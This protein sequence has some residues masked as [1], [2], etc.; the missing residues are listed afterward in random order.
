MTGAK[1]TI[2]AAEAGRILACAFLDADECWRDV[3]LL[4]E[5][6]AP[7][8]VATCEMAF[9]RAAVIKHT[10]RWYQ[11]AAT[12]DLMSCAVDQVITEAFASEDTELTLAYYGNER[13]AVVAPRTVSFYEENV[14]P[15]THLAAVF[16]SRLRVPGFSTLEIAPLFEKVSK[17]VEDAMNTVNVTQS[18]IA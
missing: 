8:P 5:H 4:R 11:P 13:L 18:S 9:A 16:A 1:R 7:G 6:E 12:A 10:I 3:C 14:F 2:P 17:E 15:L